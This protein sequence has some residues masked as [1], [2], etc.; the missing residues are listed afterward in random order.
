MMTHTKRAAKAQRRMTAIE[1]NDLLPK[2]APPEPPQ[3]H[4]V[5]RVFAQGNALKKVQEVQEH[6]NENDVIF[7]TLMKSVSKSKK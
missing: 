1:V 3:R 4:V 7:Q 6:Q 2:V 5:E